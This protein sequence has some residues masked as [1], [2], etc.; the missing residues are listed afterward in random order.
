[1]RLYKP[2]RETELNTDASKYGYGAILMQRDNEDQYFH[3][4]YYASGKTTEAKEKY[5]SYE[6]KV[7]AIIK[8]L[9]KFRVYLLGVPFTIVTDCRAFTLTMNKKDLCVRVARW[10]LLL[11]KFSYKIEHRAGKSMTHVDALSRSPL[12]CVFTIDE[13][14]EGLLAKLKRAQHEDSEIQPI[15]TRTGQ[16]TVDE[17]VMRDGLVFKIINNDELVVPKSMQS[18]IIKRAHEQGHFSANKT[19]L[20]VKRDYWFTN[21]SA[22]LVYEYVSKNREDDT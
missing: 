17:Y 11:E 14:E 18:Q 21:M 15:I 8:A 9:Q 4:V 1:M 5:H 20:L 13:G 22:K 2:T 7:L 16:N 6:L 3:P 12:P 19:E 10:T